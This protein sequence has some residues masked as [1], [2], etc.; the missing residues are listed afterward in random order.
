MKKL[1]STHWKSSTQPRK[2]RKFVFNAPLHIKGKF[3][4]ASLSKDLRNEYSI[5]SLRVRKG[6]KVKILSGEFK[7]L[8]GAVELVNLKKSFVYV[9]K[10]E[11]MRKDGTKSFYPLHASKLQIQTLNLQDKIRKEKLQNLKKAKAEEKKAQK[12]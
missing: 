9:E 6:D 11:R 10:A 8:V 3:L 7:G 2:Q 4:H 1:F 12:Q 5:R